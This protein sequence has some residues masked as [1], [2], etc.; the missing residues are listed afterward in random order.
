MEGVVGARLR[1]GAQKLQRVAELPTALLMEA[2][3][4]ASS[5][6]A[7]WQ[8]EAAVRRSVRAM[9]GESDASLRAVRR[10][11]KAG[12]RFVFATVEATDAKLMAAPKRH[13]AGLHIASPMEEAADASLRGDAPRLQKAVGATNQPCHLSCI[14]V[15]MFPTLRHHTD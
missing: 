13:V 10:A 9:E 8:P 4:G 11:H 7:P 12:S 14:C 15:I 3:A 1:E 2:D 5:R 6:A